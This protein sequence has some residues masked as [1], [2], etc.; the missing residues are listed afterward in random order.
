MAKKIV[1]ENETDCREI[2]A[3]NQTMGAKPMDEGEEE[4]QKGYEGRALKRIIANERS[5][6]VF[7]PTTEYSRP[8]FF[9]D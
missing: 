9:K 8:I 6:L 5:K 3:A 1:C 4:Q 7:W 2:D